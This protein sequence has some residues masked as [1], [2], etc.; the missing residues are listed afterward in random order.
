M[1]NYGN[2]R[3]SGGLSIGVYLK[4]NYSLYIAGGDVFNK[5]GGVIFGGNV[6]ISITN[7]GYVSNA[8][9]IDGYGTV[10]V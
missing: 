1:T 2:I 8:G 7:G 10:G 5:S 3:A 4:G 9:S 6:G